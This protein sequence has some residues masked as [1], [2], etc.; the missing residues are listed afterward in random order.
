VESA[1]NLMMAIVYIHLMDLVE[2]RP[3]DRLAS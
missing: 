1:A 2:P 3:E